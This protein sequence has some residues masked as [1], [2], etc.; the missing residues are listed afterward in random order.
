LK[1]V[2]NNLHSDRIRLKIVVI[3][4]KINRVLS[5]LDAANETTQKI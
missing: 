2:C 5:T 1:I 3:L 4:L